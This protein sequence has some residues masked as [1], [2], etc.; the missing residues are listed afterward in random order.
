MTDG[1]ILKMVEF[2]DASEGERACRLCNSGLI[3]RARLTCSRCSRRVGN[4]NAQGEYYLPDVVNIAI[5][6]GPPLR[7]DR[8]RDPDEVRAS[9][10]APNW[11]P[12]KPA[13]RKRAPRQAMA[14]GAT[15]IAPETVFFAWD[16]Q[17]GRD[18]TIEPNVSSAPA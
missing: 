18:V 8:G 16:T 5:A 15:L 4:D 17:L 3:A 11:P 14:E 2:K 7:G 6:D 1:R 12:P 10:A 9:T 13:G